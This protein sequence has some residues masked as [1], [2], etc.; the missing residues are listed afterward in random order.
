MPNKK[1][2]CVSIISFTLLLS[3]W[4]ITQASDP[5]SDSDGL[6]DYQEK[7]I[8]HTNPDYYDTDGD[9][10]DDNIEIKNGYSPRHAGQGRKL[11]DVDSDK[12]GLNDKWELVIGTDILNSDTDGDSYSDGS[13]VANGYD[14]LRE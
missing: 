7:N 9:G 13:E 6:T 11:I 8:Y 10:Y 4:L 5:D 2:A 1:V 14:P 3:F 12:D